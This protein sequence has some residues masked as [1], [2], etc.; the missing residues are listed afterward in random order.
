ME[1]TLKEQIKRRNEL[2]VEVGKEMLNRSTSTKHRQELC[3]DISTAISKATAPINVIT[4][5]YIIAVLKGFARSLSE[6]HPG[7]E[8]LANHLLECSTAVT[9]NMPCKEEK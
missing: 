4:V 2:A 1:T 8:K 5:P 9:F 6:E 7:A 3:N